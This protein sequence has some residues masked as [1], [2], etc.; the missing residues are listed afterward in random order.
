ML[1]KSSLCG[2]LLNAYAFFLYC[3]RRSSPL[4]DSALQE[5]NCTKLHLF[6][7]TFTDF[8]HLFS[9]IFIIIII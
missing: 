1:C 9:Y 8:C 7:Y 6:R 3:R 2:S 5:V 4:L